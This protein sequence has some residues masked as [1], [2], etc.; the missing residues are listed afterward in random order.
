M[1]CSQ[2]QPGGHDRLDVERPLQLCLHADW[3]LAVRQHLLQADDSRLGLVG[4]RQRLHS[5]SHLIGQVGSSSS[6]PPQ[7]SMLVHIYV[8]EMPINSGIM[9]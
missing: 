6:A 9:P 5:S 7:T 3:A 2:P 4:V 1:L 8:K